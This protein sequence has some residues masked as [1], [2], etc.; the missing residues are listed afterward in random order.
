MNGR[1]NWLVVG[2]GLGVPRDSKAASASQGWPARDPELAQA[3][4]WN[5]G[6]T[7]WEGREQKKI[8]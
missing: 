4:S 1:M 8:S 3:S 7:G 6:T 2:L 5:L